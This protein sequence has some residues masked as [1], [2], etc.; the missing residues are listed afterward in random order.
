M[1]QASVAPTACG[2]S[3]AVPGTNTK[4]LTHGVTLV[5][6]LEPKNHLILHEQPIMKI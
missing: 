2:M 1:Y 5:K 6:D 4:P 3:A